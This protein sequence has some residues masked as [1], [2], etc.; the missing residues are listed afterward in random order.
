[1]VVSDAVPR[2]FRWEDGERV[3]RFG[4]GALEQAPAEVGQGYVLLT[5]PRG[6]DQVGALADGA[7]TIHDVPS[8]RVDEVAAQLRDEVRGETLVAVGGGR[9]IDVAKALAAADPPRRVAAVPTTLSAAEMTRLHRHAAGVDPS[10]RRVRPRI[11]V[12]DPA[13]SASQ[14]E[15]GL[16]AST[17]NS[18]AH[19]V[20]ATVSVNGHPAA[21]LVARGGIRALGAGFAG[22]EPA[23]DHLALGALLSG[24]A[25]DAAGYGLHHVMAQTLVRLTPIDH[26]PANAVMLPHTLRALAAR[27]PGELAAIDEAGDGGLAAIIERIGA[28]AGP[29]RLRDWDVEA[30]E[31]PACADAALQRPEL[32][33]TPPAPDRDE[34]LAIYEAAF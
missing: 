23:R 8:G 13:L 28:R 33:L 20:E 30:D 14:P 11:V 15:P 29:R 18:L 32:A 9:V 22:P 26:G 25:S 6:R 16:A 5:T 2:P 21:T 27:F 34:L 7:A 19:A 31:L 1:M 4:R 24:W 10:T 12:N 17:L 3:I